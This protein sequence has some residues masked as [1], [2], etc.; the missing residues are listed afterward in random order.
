MSFFVLSAAE[1]LIASLLVMLLAGISITQQL[2]L[3]RPL[4]IAATRAFVQL[5]IVGHV[6]NQ[7]FQLQSL[8]WILAIIGFMLL[9]AAHEVMTRQN[10]PLLGWW[11]FGTG[12]LSLFISTLFVMLITLTS[13]IEIQPWYHPQYLIPIVGMLLGN[14]I[15]GI[16]ISLDRLF[17]DTWN[18][19]AI[20]ESRLSLGHSS[21]QAI[22]SIKKNAIRV[23]LIPLFN[24]MAV[25]GIVSLPGMM[26]GQMLAG[27]MPLEAA[28]YQI[29]IFFL[30]TAS[31]GLG[32]WGASTL[33]CYRLFDERQ[34]LRLDR[35][36]DAK[37]Q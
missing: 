10:R 23:G 18:Q 6:L 1:L 34:H 5:L 24:A 22:S 29:L 16:A 30:I 8:P 14:T 36:R 2:D 12:A 26:T 28:K 27:V 7:V 25:A 9:V 21:R 20:I 11:G 37:P 35:L 4:V 13:I 15:T 31:T 32:A 33:A 19:R 3:A 17:E